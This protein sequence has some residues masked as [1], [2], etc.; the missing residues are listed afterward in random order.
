MTDR[1]ALGHDTARGHDAERRLVRGACLFVGFGG[2]FYA[3]LTTPVALAQRDLAVPW[4]TPLA[5][6]AVYGPAAAIAL[7]AARARFDLA[8]A[9]A[10][11]F[12]AGYLLA[13]LSWAILRTGTTVPHEESLWITW[14]PGLPAVAM[15]VFWRVTPFCYLVAAAAVSQLDAALARGPAAYP[16]LPEFLFAVAYSA[17][18]CAACVVLIRI[19]RTLD[20][21]AHEVRAKA[22]TTAEA[23]AR[24]FERRRFDALTHDWVLATL[25]QASRTPNNPVLTHHADITLGDLERLRAGLPA[26]DNLDLDQVAATVR[27]AVADID[28]S[29]PLSIDVDSAAFTV[30]SDV[31]AALA[32]AVSEALRNWQRHAGWPG[33]EAACE[34]ELTADDRALRVDIVDDGVGFDPGSVPSNRLGLRAGITD[35]LTE[36]PGGWAE[37]DSAPGRGCRISA[38]WAA[39]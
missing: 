7:A 9:G 21:T 26:R 28:D 11:A 35:R 20:R 8:R 13:A 15:C 4:W 39:P 16:V 14:I 3:L 17:L 24:R 23:K 2:L 31:A 38:G 27:A 33:R 37:I 19:G 22:V 34:V 25:L 18:P 29:V 10:L 5:L 12:A 1:A 30:P 32:A 6:A 36:F